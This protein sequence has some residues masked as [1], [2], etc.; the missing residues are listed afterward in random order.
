MYSSPATP[1]GTGS[2]RRVEDVDPRVGDRPA[3]RRRSAPLVDPAHRARSGPRPSPRSARTALHQ[4]R[5][6]AAPA[7]RTSAAGSASPAS[8][9][10][11]TAAQLR[12]SG[13]SERR[14]TAGAR[15]H[16]RDPPARDHALQRVARED[17][18]AVTSVQRRAAGTA[19][20]K[21]SNTEASKLSDVEL[22]HPARRRPRQRSAPAPGDQVA[23]R[24]R[25][26][27]ITP[28]GRPVEPEV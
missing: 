3:D 15:C 24:S 21:I 16:V 8:I 10:V 11:R 25:C 26:A 17:V 4:P 23:P 13:A 6:R 27:T 18:R 1:T 20:T 19:A 12:A 9:T 7:A 5:A 14:S 28:L 2:P 22:Q